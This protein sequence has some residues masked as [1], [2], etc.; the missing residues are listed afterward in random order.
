MESKKYRIVEIILIVMI[1]NNTGHWPMT[2]H[3]Y[4]YGHSKYSIE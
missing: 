4:M 2:G 3:P 1:E